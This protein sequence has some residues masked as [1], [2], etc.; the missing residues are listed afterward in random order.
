MAK[1]SYYF[2]TIT[3]EESYFP[4][5][6][7]C[8]CETSNDLSQSPKIPLNVLATILH[9]ILFYFIATVS[10]I[11]HHNNSVFYIS[12]IVTT[13]IVTRL[14][15]LSCSGPKYD[16]SW[17][18]CC[19]LSCIFCCI[20]RTSPLQISLFSVSKS[21]IILWI[22]HIGKALKVPALVVGDHPIQQH[23]L[24]TVQLLSCHRHLNIIMQQTVICRRV[25]GGCFRTSWVCWI[26]LCDCVTFYTMMCLTIKYLGINIFVKCTMINIFII[27]ISLSGRH[28]YF[29]VVL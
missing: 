12:L 27:L 15:T 10:T 11:I 5:C 28:I 23:P 7:M 21:W 2:N 3:T 24:R 22:T 18:Y 20:T 16:D 29:L 8:L 4:L 26:S 6:L 13:V 9:F 14:L 1:I 17:Y 25:K 19:V